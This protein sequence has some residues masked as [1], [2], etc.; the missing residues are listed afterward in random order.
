MSRRIEVELTSSRSDGTW[1]WRAAGA[2]QPKGDLD[3]SLLYDGAQ[4]GDVVRADAD[5]LMDGIV[6]VGLAFLFGALAQAVR[7][8]RRQFLIVGWLALGIGVAVAL[9]GGLLA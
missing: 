5:F 6:I 3:G 9:A 4:V 1:T 7:G 2:K 8:R